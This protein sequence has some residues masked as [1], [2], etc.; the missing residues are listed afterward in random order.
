MDLGR[1][2]S[3]MEKELEKAIIEVLST[4]AGRLFVGSIFMGSAFYAHVFDRDPYVTAYRAGQRDLLMNLHGKL[5]DI[6]PM[7]PGRCAAAVD[8]FEKRYSDNNLKEE[9]GDD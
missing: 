9:E 4:D 6:D 8:E 7:L 1:K 5:A 2:E 3:L